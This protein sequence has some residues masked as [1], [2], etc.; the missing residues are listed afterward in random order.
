MARMTVL[1]AV[2]AALATAVLVSGQG[3]QQQALCALRRAV[4]FRHGM[5]RPAFLVLR[6]SAL[7]RRRGRLPWRF[8]VCQVVA[9]DTRP[10]LRW[11][12]TSRQAGSTGL[13]RSRLSASCGRSYYAFGRTGWT[14]V[15]RLGVVAV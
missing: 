7:M 5:C 1:L 15:C 12:C 13:G 3:A 8:A 10:R 9:C 6:L 14:R 11:V 2:L 4:D